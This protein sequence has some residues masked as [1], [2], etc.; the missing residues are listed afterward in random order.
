MRLLLI[1]KL[2]LLIVFFNFSLL[3][4]FTAVLSIPLWH[5]I[6]FALTLL[7]ISIFSA[8][9]NGQHQFKCFLVGYRIRTALI[10]AIYRKAL[11]LSSAA[12]RTTTVGEIV[13]LMS[14]DAQ[15]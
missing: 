1:I 11:T 12:K 14:V 9:L 5:G 13:N 2:Q 4:T 15:R 6:L 10:S 7:L 3:I 8:L